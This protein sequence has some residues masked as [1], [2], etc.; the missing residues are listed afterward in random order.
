MHK[1]TICL[2]LLAILAGIF[3]MR[4]LANEPQTAIPP[5]LSGADWIIGG[6][7]QEL[8]VFRKVFELT[9][10]AENIDSATAS[11]CGL[12]FYQLDI[13]GQTV[14]APMSPGWTNYRKTCLFNQWD[15]KKQ[16]RSGTNVLGVWLG[17][18]FFN[19]KGGRYVKFTGSFGQPQWIGRLDITFKDGSRQILVSDPSW[20]TAAGPIT[21]SCVYGGE[22]W[23]LSKDLTDWNSTEFNDESWT[24]ASL[25]AAPPAGQLKPQE[26][27]DIFV[28]E[29]LKPEKVQTL[30]DG[31]IEAD[32]GYNFSGRPRLT[33][34]GKPGTTVTVTLAET[35][36]NPWRGHSYSI[37]FPKDFDTKCAP[38]VFVPHFTYWGFQYLYVSG[39]SLDAQNT[40]D[41]QMP[42]LACV[43]AEF[44][45]SSSVKAGEFSSSAP[46]LNDIEAMIARSVRS[47]LQHVL[48]DCP[49]REKLG[50]LEVA[51]LM[52]PSIM[53]RFNIHQLYRKVCMDIS[54]AQLPNG[55]VPDIVPEY[56]RFQGGFFESPEW[57][58]STVQIPWLLYRFYGD[59]E[60]LARQYETMEKYMAYFVSTRNEQ[61]LAKAG[62]GDWYDWSEAKGHPGYSHLTPR[63]LPAT[64]F[65]ANNAQL[66]SRISL[67]LD[68]PER[69]EYYDTL[70]K[71]ASDAFRKAYYDPETGIIAQ[72]SQAGYAFALAFHLI[73]E[74]QRPR[75]MQKFL[76][77]IERMEYRPTTG[78][79]AFVYLL[80]T[81][82]EEDRNDVIAR[83]IMRRTSPGYVNMLENFG[84]KTLS[85][86]WNRPGSSMNHWMFGHAQE[87]FTAGLLGIRQTEDSCGFQEFLLTPKPC[88]QISDADGWYDSPNGRIESRWKC[89][90]G[91]FF[92]TF[93]VPEDTTA[94]VQVP[95]D[96]ERS[97]VTFSDGVS[98]ESDYRPGCR[99]Y[100]LSSG[101]YEV[102]SQ[103]T[104]RK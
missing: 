39:A 57:S 104:A 86:A 20:K 29:V 17:N 33:F 82:M 15:V 70:A 26:H 97:G 22:D 72:D 42:V 89:G 51:H 27:P 54:E 11:I 64:A 95:V 46:W 83:I 18:G 87:W 99:V 58:S 19:V 40:P 24:A 80:R 30:P 73:P 38:I 37:T 3:S 52:G 93:T 98:R 96:D 102:R 41:E 69:A 28:A 94:I 79:V 21:F 77:S 100:R 59:T 88:T 1:K 47:N 65:L 81:L 71:E 8:P 84:M 49:H 10:P 23:V 25:S 4:S 13:N 12:G 67:L 45:T 56:V 31:R 7:S 90:N 9:Q 50:W 66:M 62:L 35:K 75:V 85:E 61:G 103:F 101:K 48:T 92:W 60:I 14:S 44:T 36:N 74:E 16:L 63:E 32:F 91:T 6:S 5:A 76:E 55:M 53:Y 78:E 43:E 68:K 34:L 2:F